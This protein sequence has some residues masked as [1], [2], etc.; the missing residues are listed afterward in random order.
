MAD[1]DKPIVCINCI[2]TNKHTFKQVLG[3]TFHDRPVHKCTRITLITIGNNHL[4]CTP[5]PFSMPP[6]YAGRESSATPAPEICLF[7]LL[8]HLFRAHRGK[9]LFNSSITTNSNVM[10]DVIG[11]YSSIIPQCN[12]QLFLIKWDIFHYLNGFFKK[13]ASIKEVSYRI[14]CH[15]GNRNNSPYIFFSDLLIKIT[16]RF[17]LHNR[18]FLAYPLTTCLYNLQIQ[19]IFCN[20]LLKPLNNV[21]GPGSR[22][23]C[24]ATDPYPVFLR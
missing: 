7:Y 14:T 6:L 10:I 24:P 16:M 17:D 9:H 22:T 18:T 8:N 3:V 20:P 23:C 1:I 19:T 11:I 5:R 21:S 13:S 2:G 15:I 4:D 12:S